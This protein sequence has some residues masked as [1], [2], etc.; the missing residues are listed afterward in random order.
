ML[1]SPIFYHTIHFLFYFHLD[2]RHLHF[3]PTRRSSDLIKPFPI[4]YRALRPRAGECNNLLVPC[5]LS[6]SHAAYGSVRMEPVFMMLG[7]AAGAAAS[8]AI[9]HNVSVQELPYPAL[10][11]Q[12]LADRQIL[13]RTQPRAAE[14]PKSD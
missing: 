9:D 6:A 3:F 11:K 13:D 7:H 14:P 5:C 1:C 12:L 10:R 4:S 2:H 8:L